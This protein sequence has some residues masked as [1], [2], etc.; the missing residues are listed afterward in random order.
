MKIQ[1]EDASCLRFELSSFP[2]W[3]FWR[4]RGYMLEIAISELKAEHGFPRQFKWFLFI[5]CQYSY[6]SKLNVDILVSVEQK[7]K[8]KNRGSLWPVELYWEIKFDHMDLGLGSW[9]YFPFEFLLLLFMNRGPRTALWSEF[10]PQIFV[11]PGGRRAS[12]WGK[13]LAIWATLQLFFC[14]VVWNLERPF[15]SF[16]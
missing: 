9:N 6:S 14:S 15:Q 12:L 11:G 3:L 7:E 4:V 5:S 10:F 13:Y 1:S 16:N 2:I 8:V